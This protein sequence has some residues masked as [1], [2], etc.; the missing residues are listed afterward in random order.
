MNNF[1]QDTLLKRNHSIIYT[2]TQ[3]YFQMKKVRIFISY[4]KNDRATLLP[5]FV[6][7]KTMM[8][9]ITHSKTKFPVH[10]WWDDSIQTGMEWQKEIHQNL[11]DADVIV[12]MVSDNFLKSD[13]IRDVE[14]PRALAKR[15][16]S[17]VM[18]MNVLI[19]DCAYQSSQIS[20][21]E[22]TPKKGGRLKPLVEWSNKKECWD[23]LRNSLKTCIVNSIEN[24]PEPLRFNPNMN[25]TDKN[26][27]IRQF[28]PPEVVK[29]HQKLRSRT[30]QK[31]KKASKK[32]TLL[33][34]IISYL[35]SKL[36]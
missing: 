11:D 17:G 2:T 28:A 3:D 1:S 23:F 31:K 15:E 25:P 20:H 21:I 13:F 29:L 33:G 8:S 16:S 34:K 22:W 4:A 18:L 6:K 12:F 30:G 27:H 35:H 24:L 26:M 9:S 5:Y 19:E 10:F 32:K 36:K 14:I 7:F